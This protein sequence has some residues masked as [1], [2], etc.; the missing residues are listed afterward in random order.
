MPLKI[1]FEKETHIYKGQLDS[2][3]E[4][5]S[6]ITLNF[7]S[8]PASFSLYYMDSDMDQITLSCDEDIQVLKE[9]K[10]QI[11]IYVQSTCD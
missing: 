6:Y 5:L 10:S 3:K 9:S 7:K 11:K 1:Q 8:L 4:L 2:F